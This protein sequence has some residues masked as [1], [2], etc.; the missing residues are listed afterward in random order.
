MRRFRL[1][2]FVLL[3]VLGALPGAR[4]TRAEPEA[5]GPRTERWYEI[6]LRGEKLGH[7]RVVWA[8][9]T[10]EGRK[11]VHDTTTS[12][13]RSVRDMMGMKDVFETSMVTDL[14]RGEDG[15]LWWYRA[16]VEEAGR[17]TV[18]EQTWTGEGYVD[19]TRLGDDE[20]RKVEI[21]TEEPVAV[22]A[23]SWLGQRIRDEEIH[24]GDRVELPLLDVRARKVRIFPLTVAAREEIDDPSAGE[25]AKTPTFK[26][27]QTDPRTGAETTFWIDDDGALVKVTDDTGTA[28]VRVPQATAEK[29]P[30]HPAESR[31]TTPSTPQLER[32]MSADRLLVDLH[33]QGDPDRKRPAFPDSP[34][35]RAQ[36]VE[37]SDEAGWVYH[38]ILTRY[39]DPKAD[40]TLPVDPA[41]FERDLEPTVLMQCADATVKA[42]AAEVV[43]EEKS[44][45]EAARRLSRWVFENLQKASPEVGQASA[46]EILDSRQGDCSEHALLFVALCRA[47]GIPARRCSG[48]VNVGSVWGAH[49][50]A[51]VWVG[52]WIGAD[53]TTGEI[54]TAARYLFFGYSD[55][56]E[57]S[58]GLVSARASGRMRF[59]A[60]EIREGSETWDLRDPETWRV[61]DRE[62]GRYVN[63]LAGIEAKDVPRDWVVRVQGA[64][65]MA[66]R[67]AG[68]RV[69]IDVMADQGYRLD[70]IG[71]LDDTFAG[72]PARF[73]GI[74]A[75]TQEL[76]VHS[77]RR[78]LH[79]T[80]SGEKAKQ[81]RP[82]LEKVLAPTFAKTP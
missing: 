60:T 39:D 52:K 27:V 63:V 74:A 64:T 53:P 35:S 79:I 40:T 44:A 80:I 20:P 48:Y 38:L 55:D 43:G 16:V 12:V 50:W 73:R 5:E 2:P 59:V 23:E 1:V 72:Q 9:S 41:G 24:V 6:R 25:D 31:I 4:T 17:R 14:E 65:G 34:W 22:D 11:T 37:G 32:V 36:S 46:L 62:K 69:E 33:L 78:I 66:F 77:R 81:L 56:P 45:R 49:A 26:V 58:P 10:W 8:P 29:K 82:T 75:V 7:A 67:A 54:G 21:P 68:L 15:R 18:E 13:Q 3:T 47:A 28:W 57:S 30:V 42:V 61:E 51:E 71:G 19:V 76:F 70:A